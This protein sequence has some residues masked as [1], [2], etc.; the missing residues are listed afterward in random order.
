MPFEQGPIRP[1]SEAESLLIRVTRNC[2]W[3]QCLFCPVY[4]GEKF[5]R[6]EVEEIKEDIISIKEAAEKIKALS[7]KLGEGGKVTRDVL[8]L[9]YR[10]EPELLQVAFWL[11]RGGKHVFLQDADSMVIPADQL[12]EVIA[13]IREQFPGVERITTYARSKTLARKSVSQL[14]MLKEAGLNRVHIGLETGHDPLLKYI[15]KGVTAR[16]HLVA[17]LK[18]KEAGLSLSEYIILGLGGRKL[19]REHAIDTAKL[20]SEINP[21]FIRV[22][23]LGVREGIPL[24]ERIEAGDFEMM[25]DD[26]IVREEKLLLENL[27]CSSYFVSDHILNLLE[28]VEGQLPEDLPAMLNVIDSYL[29][30]PEEEKANFRLGRRMGLYRRL[31]D[32]NEGNLYYRVESLKERLKAEGKREEDLLALYRGRY[33]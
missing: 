18:A 8:E 3:N 32:M 33:I 1:P 10:M 11:H 21:H 2:P 7:F 20:L 9:V 22:R 27:N 6:R 25:S 4:K 30:L 23:T 29:A 5:S 31:R 26:E 28:E 13:F 15:R 24:L 14:I 16:E 19:W 17:G 12:A